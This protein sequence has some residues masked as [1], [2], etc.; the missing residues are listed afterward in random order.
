[1]SNFLNYRDEVGFTLIE[2]LV[3]LAIS[4]IFLAGVIKIFSTSS[5][6]YSLQ[7]DITAMQQNL[8]VGDM[9]IERDVRMAG[10]GMSGQLYYSGVANNAIFPINF[11]DNIS[12]A[13][14]SD[15]LTIKYV[16]ID[17]V[18]CSGNA[19]PSLTLTSEMPKDSA[20]AIVTQDLTSSTQPPTPPYTTW[21][22]GFYCLG[23]P[24]CDPTT[25][26]CTASGGQNAYRVIITSP[27][28]TKSDLLNITQVIPNS[29][30]LQNNA[31]QLFG[32]IGNKIMNSYPAG[33][34]ISFFNDASFFVVT[35]SYYPTDGTLHRTTCAA[36]LTTTCPSVNDSTTTI[37]DNIEDLQFAFGLDTTG[38]GTVD[39]W[40]NSGALTAAQQSQI[41]L[42]RINIL[43]RTAHQ[44]P[45]QTS[46]RQAVE[47][48]TAAT[49]A[50]H[51][52][53]QLLTTTVEVRNMR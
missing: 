47:D 30:K 28:G 42:V 46:T 35:Y 32:G 7:E 26:F 6:S 1:M 9:F 21:N 3:A 4:S 20:V 27:D 29:N 13:A 38:N 12:G 33:S 31:S 15:T 18:S 10:C 11:T 50:D 44:H 48:H 34:T 45:G 8:R 49:V 17:S 19:P 52:T 37:A 24:M 14:N 5:T 39:T 36:N 51:Y 43:G 23:N 25:G 41:R 53:R 22:D 40:V 2:L 16:K